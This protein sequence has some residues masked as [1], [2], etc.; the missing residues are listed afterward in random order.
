MVR[1][2]PALYRGQRTSG[3][4][5]RL[6]IPAA[7][8]R[9]TVQTPHIHY[10]TKNGL[11]KEDLR[12]RRQITDEIIFFRVVS[13]IIQS[14]PGRGHTLYSGRLNRSLRGTGGTSGISDPRGGNAPYFSFK[15]L[16]LLAALQPGIPH[17]PSIHQHRP[18][19]LVLPELAASPCRP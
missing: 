18:F 1:A 6:N 19:R 17:S 15:R 16:R 12:E 10:A 4:K 3:A 13:S 2:A 7:P 8:G 11:F 9:R 14:N 5:A